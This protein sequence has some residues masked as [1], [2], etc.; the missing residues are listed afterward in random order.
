MKLF[1]LTLALFALASTAAFAADEK[2]KGEGK[3]KAN[4]EEMFKKLDTNNDGS[5]SLDEYKAGP[6]GKKDPAKAEES[7]KKHD[8]NGDGKLSL[9]EMTAGGGKKKEK[10][11][12]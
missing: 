11:A 6:A 12:N 7:F 4:P 10:A 5:L 9:E 1:P 2:P 3:P 8:K